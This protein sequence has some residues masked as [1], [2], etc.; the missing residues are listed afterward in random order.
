MRGARCEVRGARCVWR[1]VEACGG[2]WRRVE[3]WGGV[4][5]RGEAVG[6]PSQRACE[7][8]AELRGVARTGCKG[9]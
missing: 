2:V 7:D 3:A 6:Y 1:R 8:E 4:W 5:R 9:A